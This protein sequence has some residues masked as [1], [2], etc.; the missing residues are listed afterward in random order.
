M[1]DRTL[2]IVPAFGQEGN[3]LA[4]RH[5]EKHMIGIARNEDAL[6]LVHVDEI[7]FARLDVHLDLHA[8]AVHEHDVFVEFRMAMVAAD[9]AGLDELMRELKDGRVGHKGKNGAASV[10]DGGQVAARLEGFH[11]HKFGKNWFL[12]G[13]L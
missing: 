8:D 6:A 3:G 2:A 1:E 9:L 10:A 5:G 12:T 4:I 11:S 7:F 13:K